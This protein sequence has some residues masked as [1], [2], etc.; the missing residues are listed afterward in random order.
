MNFTRVYG[1]VLRYGYLLRRNFDR[2]ADAFYWPTIDLFVWGLTGLYVEQL[3]GN[4]KIITAILSG[5]VLWYVVYRAQ[6][7]ITVNLLEEFWNDNLVNIFVAP[8]TFGEWLVSVLLSGIIK[9]I[10]SLAFAALVAFLLYQANVFAYGLAAIPFIFLLILSGWFVGLFIAGLI[11]R[12]G[13]KIQFL[14]WTMVY[15]L[16]PFSAVFYPVSILPTWAEKVAA[17]IPMSYVFEGLRQVVNTGTF[18]SQKFWI[19]L[20]LNLVYL[21]ATVLFVRN[22]F[23]KALEKGL[24]TIY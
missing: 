12:Y 2:A 20:G 19:S 14:S 10:T 8:V 1:L 3:A 6:G 4:A 5:V 15:V 21:G 23:K 16:F 7:E 9:S 13:T 24:I 11:L 18:D 22:G 17:F